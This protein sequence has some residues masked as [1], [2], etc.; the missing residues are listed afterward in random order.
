MNPEIIV[1]LTHNDVT[2]S[3]ARQ[4]FAESAELPVKYWGFKDNGLSFVELG[5]LAKDMRDAGKSA[6]LEV[7]NFDERDLLKSMELAVKTGIEYFTGGAFSQQ[8]LAQAKEVGMKYYPFCGKAGGSP[9]ELRGS[10][11]S[12]IDDAKRLIDFGVDGV[13]LVAY[14]YKDGDPIELAKAAIDGVG[15]ENLVIAGSIN[16]R[17]RMEIMNA[18]GPFAYTM[19]GALFDGSFV[20]DGSFYENL[21]FVTELKDSLGVVAS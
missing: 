16:S 2:V 19:G 3:N 6:V 14:R 11:Q 10:H 20:P 7:V 4:L 13:D 9:I 21:K 8:A 5:N 17:E 1:M 18:V 15:A 12:V